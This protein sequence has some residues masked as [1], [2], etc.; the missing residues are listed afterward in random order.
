VAFLD[1]NKSHSVCDCCIT[2]NVH[3][4]PFVMLSYIEMADLK[5]H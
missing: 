1:C 3:A 5:E 2:N 4:N